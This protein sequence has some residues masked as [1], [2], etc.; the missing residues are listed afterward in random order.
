LFKIGGRYYLFNIVWP[1]GGMRTVVV[2][3]ADRLTGPYEGRVVL[4]DRGHADF[5]FFR[6]SA[7]TPTSGK[8]KHP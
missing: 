5:D 1:R 6:P 7:T 3:R 4:Q 8:D 2:H